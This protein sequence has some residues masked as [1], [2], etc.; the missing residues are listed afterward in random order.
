[1]L[2][3]FPGDFGPIDWEKKS[4]NE[5]LSGTYARKE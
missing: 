1:M 4:S 5:A 3:N 2:E